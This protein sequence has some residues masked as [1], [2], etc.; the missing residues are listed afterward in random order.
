M[1]FV[2]QCLQ[3][4]LSLFWT[5]LD[6]VTILHN[7]LNNA[8]Y[9]LGQID[10]EAAQN[11]VETIIQSKK[12]RGPYVVYTPKE[13]FEIGKYAAENGTSKAVARY[14]SR[15]PSLKERTVRGFQSK[16]ENEIK[17]AATKKLGPID[18]MVQNYMRVSIF[19]FWF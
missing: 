9:N 3:F 15:F 17:I 8:D 12:K 16:Y 6:S 10:F 19:S 1:T 5:L 13:S 4:F 14:K 11:E 2:F 7:T 18:D